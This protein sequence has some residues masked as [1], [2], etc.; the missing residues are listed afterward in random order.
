MKPNLKLLAVLLCSWW[1]M[2]AQ[3]DVLLAVTQPEH[4]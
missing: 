1:A 3:A 2:T 4:P